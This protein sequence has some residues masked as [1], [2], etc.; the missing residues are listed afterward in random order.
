MFSLFQ[1]KLLLCVSTADFRGHSFQMSKK[2][3]LSKFQN[4]FFLDAHLVTRKEAEE[5]ICNFLE[6]FLC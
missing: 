3:S 6:S 2:T 5:A 1:A 4:H